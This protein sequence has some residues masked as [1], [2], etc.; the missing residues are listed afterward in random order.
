MNTNFHLDITPNSRNFCEYNPI[1]K[2]DTKKKKVDGEWIKERFYIID[3]LNIKRDSYVIS[4]F[5]RVFSFSTG[6]EMTLQTKSTGYNTVQLRTTDGGSKRVMVARLVA[7]AFIPKTMY[8]KYM[9][10]FF[11]HHK[12]WKITNDY[13]WNLEWKSS[14]EIKV[15]SDIHKGGLMSKEEAVRYVCIMMEKGMPCSQIYSNF[16]GEFSL[17]TIYDIKNGEKFTE[18][19]KD[20]SIINPLKIIK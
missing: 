1:N 17:K 9:N 3:F 6:E 12:D 20:F 11:V 2:R 15:L 10:R 8:D 18:I 4:S 14:F 5:G 7:R 19:S 13:V 16:I